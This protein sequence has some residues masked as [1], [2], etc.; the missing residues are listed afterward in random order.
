MYKGITTSKE[1][2]K[3]ILIAWI[4]IAFV[5]A[6][7]F[8]GLNDG[9]FVGLVISLFTVGIAFVVHELSHKVVAQRM[10]YSAEFKK[11]TPMLVVSLILSFLGTVF[12]APG[13]VVIE[14]LG[15]TNSEN[16]KIS[17]AGPLSNLIMGFIAIIASFFVPAGGFSGILVLFAFVNCIIGL[18]NMI[19]FWVL[20]GKKVFSWD[21][22]VYVGVLIMFFVLYGIIK[23]SM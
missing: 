13:A 12:V 1:E 19:P 2:V 16:G 14:G 20:D 21:K 3:D 6:I 17:L 8:T 11:S 23:F 15:I 7:S 22:K 9:F 10:G 18:F 5:I 4:A